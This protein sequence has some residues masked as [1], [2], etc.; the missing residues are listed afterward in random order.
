[1]GEPWQKPGNK[2]RQALGPA[3]QSHCQ[4]PVRSH[5][6]TAAVDSFSRRPQDSPACA[7]ATS[8]EQDAQ[9]ARIRQATHTTTI[10]SLTLRGFG[11]RSWLNMNDS[12]RHRTRIAPRPALQFFSIAPMCT[13]HIISTPCCKY[14]PT[15]APFFPNRHRVGGSLFRDRDAQA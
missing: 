7:F 8:A 10:A 5:H 14:E 2:S 11:W 3:R 13:S 15:L 1:M 4:D 6:G 9:W 12:T